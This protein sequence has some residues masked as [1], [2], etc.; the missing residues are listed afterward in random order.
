MRRIRH[1]LEPTTRDYD[2]HLSACLLTL[3]AFSLAFALSF[4]NGTNDVSKAIATLVGSGV[5][6]YRSAIAWGTV[7]TMVGAALAAFVASAM[8]KTFGHGLI[9]AG[10]VIEPTVTLALLIG[11]MA[12]ILFASRTG[13]PVSTTH[14]LTGPL[15]GTGL[16]AFTGE[17]LIWAAIGKKDCPSLGAQSLPRLDCLTTRPSG[18]WL[19]RGKVGRSL[20]VCHA[21]LPYIS[22]H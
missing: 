2:G 14:A 4:A 16:V 22:G 18:C 12:W 20:L 17:G 19:S 9:Q 11:A 13:F 6:N 10:T 15:V 7:W 1:L 3:L 21:Y 8:I 5:T